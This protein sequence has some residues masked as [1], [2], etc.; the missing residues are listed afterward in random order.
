MQRIFD[1][2][3]STVAIIIL[4]PI[5]LVIM[6]ILR[7]TGEKEV[8]YRQK[9][10]G[11][12]GE[13]FGV[14]KFATMVKDSSK[15]GSGFITTKN[16]PRVLPVGRFL[17]KTKLN[18]LPQLLNI[19]VGDMSFVGPRPQV[20]KHFNL[21]SENVKAELNKVTPGLTGI[22]SIV[23]RDEESIL[24]LNKNLSYEECYNKVIA[25]YKG[26]LELWYI[27]NKSTGLYL[28]IIFITAWVILFPKSNIHT[29]IFRSL[30]PSPGNLS[31]QPQV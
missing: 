17:R 14:F 12:R 2:I 3:L 4:S 21:Y 29:K 23:F 6:M 10:V 31:L 11:K 5:F 1:L 18:E 26:E 20:P 28:L 16:D 27:R 19:F 9:R 24:E 7:F 15:M 13:T 22:G 8:F 30:P 25:P